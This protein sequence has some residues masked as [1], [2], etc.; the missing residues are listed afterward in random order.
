MSWSEQG[1]GRTGSRAWVSPTALHGCIWRGGCLVRLHVVGAPIERGDEAFGRTRQLRPLAKSGLDL[2][3][4][5]WTLASASFRANPKGR[6]AVSCRAPGLRRSAAFKSASSVDP[7]PVLLSVVDPKTVEDW[8]LDPACRTLRSEDRP[9]R[10]VGEP[11][12]FA[13][14][15]GLPGFPLPR[16]PWPVDVR[17]KPAMRQAPELAPMCTVGPA[18]VDKPVNIGARI[19]FAIAD[20][21]LALSTETQR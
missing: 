11:G 3:V 14:G 4:R 21:R 10:R 7:D 13:G 19:K 9:K 12:R 5:V 17:T 16:V 8:S 20:Q 6:S 18:A 1:R 2:A 15:P